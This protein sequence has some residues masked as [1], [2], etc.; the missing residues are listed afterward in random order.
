ME[1]LRKK[2]K[3]DSFSSG[4]NIRRPNI[5]YNDKIVTINKNVKVVVLR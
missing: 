1:V 5:R 3:I 4:P 2:I